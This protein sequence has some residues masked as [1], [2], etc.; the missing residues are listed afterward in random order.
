M[1]E[2]RI[3][4]GFEN[5]EVS[6]LG[7]V[8]SIERSTI[9]SNGVKLHIKERILKHR[10][11][12]TGY[13]SVNLCFNSKAKSFSI[14]RLVAIYFISNNENFICVNHINGIKTDNRLENL[15]WCTHSENTLHA[16]ELGLNVNGEQR[17]N[18]KITDKEVFE[19]K[20]STFSQRKLSVLY[21]V[22]QSLISRIKSGE[23]RKNILENSPAL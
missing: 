22:D 18:S 8:K 10:K 5:Y 1:E 14:H 4:E 16:F 19:I 23:R 20:T 3:I 13:L 6:N 15:E 2:Y 9:R 17:R 12:G 21:G 7:N 11:D